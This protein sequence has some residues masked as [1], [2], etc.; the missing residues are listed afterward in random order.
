[1]P[2]P[3][4]LVEPNPDD[5]STNFAPLKPKSVATLRLQ[6]GQREF[7]QLTRITVHVE[8]PSQ[9]FAIV[10]ISFSLY[11]LINLVIDSGKSSYTVVRYSGHSTAQR[12]DLSSLLPN[13]RY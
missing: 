3:V 12:Q 8:D 13:A 5:S 9:L 10:R 1:M 7:K 2:K 6:S 11:R 4:D